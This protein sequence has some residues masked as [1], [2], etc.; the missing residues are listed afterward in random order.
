MAKGD[1]KAAAAQFQAA[2]RIAPAWARNQQ[3]L[4]L[5]QTKAG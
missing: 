3:M 5:A 4:R 2:A 1:V